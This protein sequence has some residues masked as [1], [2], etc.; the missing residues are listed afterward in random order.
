MR[1]ASDGV[2]GALNVSLHGVVYRDG[3]FWVSHCLELDIVGQGKTSQEAFE[4]GMEMCMVQLDD[5]LAV[6]DL[7]SVIRPAP[8]EY[9]ALFYRAGGPRLGDHAARKPVESVEFRELCPTG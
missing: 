9:W 7:E 6:G 5:A 1:D 2:F 4:N 3:D 8:P